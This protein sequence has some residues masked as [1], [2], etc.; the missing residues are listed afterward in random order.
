[1][2]IRASLALSVYASRREPGIHI[3]QVE[4][5]AEMLIEVGSGVTCRVV[6]GSEGWHH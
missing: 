6:L 5:L 2:G 4:R 1:M 3:T